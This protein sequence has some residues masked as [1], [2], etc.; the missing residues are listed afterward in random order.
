MINTVQSAYASSPVNKLQYRAET[1]TTTQKQK[2][3]D[4]VTIS[5]SARKLASMTPLLSESLDFF[6]NDE[7][8]ETITKK[9][10]DDVN[11][12][13]LENGISTDPPVEL[14]SDSSGYVRVKGDHPQKDKIE[15]LFKDNRDLSNDFRG[16]SVKNSIAE[17]VKL[18]Q[19]FAKAYEKDPAEALA[20][21]GHL[22]NKTNAKEFSMIIGGESQES[23]FV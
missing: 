5:D 10:K 18:S 8:L 19:E 15:Q 17:A 14:T 16:I 7:S 21:Y 23:E 20:R 1:Q 13:F 4:T 11:I 12:L 6:D 3:G 2:S 9:F 22:F